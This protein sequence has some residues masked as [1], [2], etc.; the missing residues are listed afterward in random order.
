MSTVVSVP[1]HFDQVFADVV[2]KAYPA[3]LR[4]AQRLGEEGEDLVQEVIL[5]IWQQGAEAA[6]EPDALHSR[7]EMAVIT[8]CA[9]RSVRI[10]DDMQRRNDIPWPVVEAEQAGDQDHL[11][12][13]IAVAFEDLPGKY[14]R[15]LRLRYIDGLPFYRTARILHLRPGQLD[16]QL[17]AALDLLRQNTIAEEYMRSYLGC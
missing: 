1:E 8:Q 15:V 5:Q 4:L 6:V 10:Y 2:Q 16:K 9:Q 3:L 13:P 14:R 11:P 7:L 17:E 12:S